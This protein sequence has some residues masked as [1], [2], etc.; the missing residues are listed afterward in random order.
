MPDLA[1]AIVTPIII[2]GYLLYLNWKLA[3]VLFIPVILEFLSQI[4]MF[5]GMKEMMTHYHEL[6][7]NLILL[8]FN[9]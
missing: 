4:G 7:K 5:K 8:L 3:L 6:V 1:A 2:I 9:I